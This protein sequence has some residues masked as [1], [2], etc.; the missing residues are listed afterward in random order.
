MIPPLSLNGTHWRCIQPK[1]S[2]Y[3]M[4]AV[5]TDGHV[6]PEWDGE[7]DISITYTT[8]QTETIKLNDFQKSFKQIKRP[9]PENVVAFKPKTQS[10]GGDR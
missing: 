8:G 6:L 4:T 7:N 3:G 10:N 1:L 2:T 5:V 9:D